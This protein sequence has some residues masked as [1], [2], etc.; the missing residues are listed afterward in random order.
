MLDVGHMMFGAED[1]RCLAQDVW[2]VF[3]T[4]C[5]VFDGVWLRH[6]SSPHLVA[7]ESM[8]TDRL[9]THLDLNKDPKRFA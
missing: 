9:A 8:R 7:D 6:W 2:L 3:A 1:V 4:D 5:Q